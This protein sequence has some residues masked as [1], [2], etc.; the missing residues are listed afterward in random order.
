VAALTLPEVKTHLDI[1]LTVETHNVELEDFIARAEGAVETRCGPLLSEDVTARVRGSRPMLSVSDTPILELTSVTP[2]GG[3]ALTLADLVVERPRAGVIEYQSG[4]RFGS[5]WYVV[6]YKCGWAATAA[7][8]PADLKAGTLELL[9]HMWD[10]QRAT[11]G[12]RIGSG[13]ESAA[14]TLPGS[15]YLLPFRVEQLL[16]PFMKV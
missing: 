8:L 6:V 14:N 13:D 9:R 10:T 5:R 4:A 1:D 12:G 7:A 15:A 3:S 11:S 16:A 2:V